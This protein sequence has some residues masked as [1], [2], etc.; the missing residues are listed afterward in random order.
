MIVRD[1]TVADLNALMQFQTSMAYET[2]QIVLDQEILK[3]GMISLFDDPGKGKYYVAEVDSK[4][5]GCLM[6]TFEWSEWRN[7]NVLWIQSVYVDSAFRGR[8]VYKTMYAY[9]RRLAERQPE[10]R[11]IRLYADK[12]NHAAMSVYRKLGM[13]G[14]HY[15]VFEWMKL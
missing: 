1:A 9:I 6:T 3:M 15:Q 12:S 14:D 10:I 8:G 11:G 2:E 5:A 13:N 4:L 7:G